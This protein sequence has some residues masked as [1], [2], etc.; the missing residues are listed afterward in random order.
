MKYNFDEQKAVYFSSKPI[1]FFILFFT[2]IILCDFFGVAQLLYDWPTG[3]LDRSIFGIVRNW[4]LLLTFAF[5][6][7]FHFLVGVHY[8]YNVAMGTMKFAL[9]E[10]LFSGLGFLTIAYF[11]LRF[12]RLIPYIGLFNYV[13]KQ[14]W[15]FLEDEFLVVHQYSLLP[16][17][18]KTV[19]IAWQTIK[20]VQTNYGIFRKT[21]TLELTGPPYK[22]TINCNRLKVSCIELEQRLN[23]CI[24]HYTHIPKD[25]LLI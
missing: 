17:K 20:S 4:S 22:I 14:P 6:A 21:V 15:L 12:L 16:W 24:R 9:L 3:S 7:C 18:I 1:W 23:N 10:S 11:H 8:F 13:P 19:L 2:F 5:F 25:D